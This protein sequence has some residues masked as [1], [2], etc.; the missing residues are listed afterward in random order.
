MRT[1]LS[2]KLVGILDHMIANTGSAGVCTIDLDP[3]RFIIKQRS[4]KTAQYCFFGIGAFSSQETPLLAC[5]GQTRQRH[6]RDISRR[7][8]YLET[9]KKSSANPPAATEVSEPASH[10]K[11]GGTSQPTNQPISHHT[12][13]YRQG[14]RF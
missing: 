2:T 11:K 10:L 1:E 12:Y 7:S 8:G 6:E 5:F 9:C 13:S 3:L 14:G 4:V